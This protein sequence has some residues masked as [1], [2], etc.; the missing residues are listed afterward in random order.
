[1]VGPLEYRYH[2]DLPWPHDC[3]N[4]GSDNRKE[5]I[6][7]SGTHDCIHQGSAPCHRTPT[8]A[9]EAL[10]SHERFVAGDD[11]LNCGAALAGF[12]GTVTEVRGSRRLIVR[13]PSIGRGLLCTLGDV[14]V[15]KVADSTAVVA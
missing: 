7:T 2:T 6:E 1:M 4:P 5:R 8:T 15:T 12:R 10:S 14:A 9:V 3:R 11:V 13:I